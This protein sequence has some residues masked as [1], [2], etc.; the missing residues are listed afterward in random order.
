MGLVL[1]TVFGLFLIAATSREAGSAPNP[2]GARGKI[3]IK[4]FRAEPVNIVLGAPNGDGT[5]SVLLGAAM[6]AYSTIKLTGVSQY[7]EY[8]FAADFDLDGVVDDGFTF[9]MTNR[10]TVFTY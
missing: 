4:N 3:T 2:Y 8:D 7:T 1:A 6:P 5:Y 9:Y 10:Y